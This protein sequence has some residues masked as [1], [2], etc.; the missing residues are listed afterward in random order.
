MANS[1]LE[2][3]ICANKRMIETL[4]GIMEPKINEIR[5]ADREEG[6]KE[7]IQGAIEMLRYLQYKDTEIRSA[8]MKQYGLTEKELSE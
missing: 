6:R 8:I 3:S 2:V 7:G 1:I 5:K 4:M